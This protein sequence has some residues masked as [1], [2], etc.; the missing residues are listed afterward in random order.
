MKIL[1]T[2]T[3]KALTL[4]IVLF[5]FASSTAF[6]EENHIP[7]VTENTS[8]DTYSDALRELE[9]SIARAESSQDL[10]E[11][12]A[13]VI[14]YDINFKLVKT[15]VINS[16]IISEDK[17]LLMILRNSSEFMTFENT[18]YYIMN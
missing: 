13:R 6:A 11:L 14:V 5:V 4:S 8:H 15:A 18:T 2:V 16:D 3:F 1:H 17:E 7:E 9:T 10:F 12:D